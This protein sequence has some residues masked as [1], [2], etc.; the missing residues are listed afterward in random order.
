MASAEVCKIEPGSVTCG[1]GEVDSL[2]GNGTVSV[3]GTTIIGSTNINGMLK[4]DDANFS[5]MLINGTAT[6]TQCTI[7]GSAN[8][9][10][11]ITASSSVF[12][13]DLDIYSNLSRFINSKITGDLRIH[14][15]DQKKQIVYLDNN[16]EVVGNISFKSKKG[17]VILRGNSKIQG[18]VVGGEIIHK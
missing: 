13:S 7:N 4:G 14:S 3:N 11:T 15:T 12:Q 5:S 6:L 8:I 10:G 18:R 16:S 9:K 1:T 17:G 2:A